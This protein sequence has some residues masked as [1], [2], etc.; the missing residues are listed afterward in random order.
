[1][2]SDS[3]SS[4]S[5]TGRRFKTESTR[6]KDDYSVRAK[7][8][9]GS[10]GDSR[11][12]T[13]TRCDDS[14]NS[15]GQERRR[16][17]SQERRDSHRRRKRSKS[18]SRS[19]DRNSGRKRLPS[20]E[21]SR[22]RDHDRGRS[23]HSKSPA[24]RDQ[25][26]GKSDA[27]DHHERGENRDRGNSRRNE[28]DSPRSRVTHDKE[29]IPSN[30]R[31]QKSTSRKNS[32]NSDEKHSNERNETREHRQHGTASTRDRSQRE[33]R[34]SV[35]SER[36]LNSGSRA[37]EQLKRG[38]ER[39]ARVD[40][41]SSKKDKA[42][43]IH[44]SSEDENSHGKDSPNDDR[45]K[46]KK[47]KHKKHKRESKRERAEYPDASHES[48]KY[49]D[50]R[51]SLSPTD[52]NERQN[53]DSSYESVRIESEENLMC[54]P[55]LPPHMLK[56]DQ[57]KESRSRMSPPREFEERP[58]KSYGPSLPSDFVRCSPPDD[59]HR[60]DSAIMDISDSEDDDFVGPVP[61]EHIANKSE[62]HLELE[63]RALE[64]K[65]AKLNEKEKMLDR[66]I[67]KRREDWMLELPEIRT[68]ADLG[69][70]AR[71]FRTKERDEI[72]DRSGWTDT[73]QD[74]QSK[75]SKKGHTHEDLVRTQNRET[76]RMYRQRRDAEQEE[77][78]RKHKKKHKR[79]ES[80][81][82]MHQKKMKKKKEKE[83]EKPVRKPFSRETDLKVNR[84]DEAQ[85]KSVLKK[86]QLLDTRFSSGQSKYL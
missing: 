51:R 36:R 25:I 68:V 3:E 45:S 43:A 78:A 61:I 85:K 18:R 49:V 53:G 74:R 72:G 58:V 22:S 11:A 59:Y 19:R 65:L 60:P 67:E 2:F 57:P 16:S 38:D 81:L 76:E 33:R 63:K 41:P 50:R 77:A 23:R 40:E 4:D 7:R 34:Q 46:H 52:R 14:N 56:K 26:K 39:K 24:Q 5:D 44:K 73:P 84:F 64:L 75:S 70:T 69:L 35:S 31:D 42:H 27:R 15:K 6:T 29:R 48:T 1:M 66:S 83:E 12:D 86:A 21:K 28:R 13:S 55:S 20:R 71:Q 47:S 62:A 79:D 54:G 10:N 9:E 17:K 82:E 8:N 32:P 37:D 30:R 80:L